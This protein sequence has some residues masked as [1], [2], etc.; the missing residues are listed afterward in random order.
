MQLDKAAIRSY[1]F[2][3]RRTK[4]PTSVCRQDYDS[5]IERL[6]KL[7]GVTLHDYVFETEGGLHSH[8]IF[9]I[10]V[11]TD[12]KRFRFRGWHI[13]LSELNEGHLWDL[14]LN[15]HQPELTTDLQDDSEEERKTTNLIH[16]L[17]RYSLIPPSD[18]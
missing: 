15:K 10:P 4:N 17:T 6:C 16:R 11:K 13:H 2:T 12:F 1:G 7:P 3:L 14:Y 18:V 9:I 8:G 5:H